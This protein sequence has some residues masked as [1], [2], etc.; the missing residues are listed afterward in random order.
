MLKSD[1]PS[2]DAPF[3]DL[4]VLTPARAYKNRHASILLA[5]EATAEAFAQAETV[6]CA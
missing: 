2:P 3:E 1:G 5:A 6:N 4:A